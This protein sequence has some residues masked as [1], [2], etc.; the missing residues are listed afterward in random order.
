ML[1]IVK[2]SG[3]SMLVAALVV[4]PLTFSP[5]PEA[6]ADAIETNVALG[7]AT[8]TTNG[9]VKNAVSLAKLVDGDRQ[10]SA[11]ALI[12]AAAGPKWV[13]LDLGESF[14]V[15][16]VNVLNDF[17]PSEPRT[18]RDI[19]VQLSND[20]TF[21]S[22]VTTVFNNDAD[23]TA[24]QGAGTDAAYMEPTDGSG[25]NVT[26]SAP[27][28]ARYVRS[29]ANGHV[30][31]S[32]NSVQTV[33]TPVE[34][35]V[36][37]A[38]P[39]TNASL[40]SAV[41]LTA[42]SPGVNSVVL[43]WTSPG[44]SAVAGYDIRYSTSPITSANW[45][46]GLVVKRVTGEP[47]PA[48][49]STAQ[50]MTVKGLPSGTPLYFAMK[51]VGST[52]QVS[53][54]SSAVS[55]STL[56]VAN[57]ALG[58]PVTTN[59]TINASGQP[60]SAL[61]D[62]VKTRDAY[63]LYSVADGPKWAQIDLG[64]TYDIARINIRNDW[65]AS[66]DVYRYARDVVVQLS[67]DASFASGVVTAFN[68]DGDNSA[69]LGAGT[70]AEYMEPA[71]GSGKDILLADTV[72]ARYVRYW[73][74]GHVRVNGSV[75]TVDTPV[76]I[77]VYADPQDSSPPAAVTNLAS[78][79]VS[80][81]S[82]DLAWTA[83]GGDGNT[84]TAVAYDLRYATSAIT[85]SNWSS[86]TPVSGVPAP[87]TAGSAE[88]FTVTGLT[89]GTTYYFALKAKDLVN[90]SPISN[91]ATV[92]TPAADTVAP[93]AIA[94][95][96][97]TQAMFKSVK[98]TWTAPGDDGSN[99]KAA[100]YDV[101]YSTSPITASNWASATQAEDELP[102]PA[103]GTPMQFKV[104]ELTAGVTYYFAVRTTD[105]VG[106][107]S[108]LSNSASATIGTPTADAVTVSSL[109]ALQTAIDGAPAG[110]RV[111]T[112]AA[113][114]Y[115]QTTPINITGKNN[116]TIRGAGSNY[117]ATVVKGLGINDSALDINFKVNDSDYV[118]FKNMTIQDSYYHAIQV[119]LGSKYF[120][121]DGLKTW[122]NGEGGFKTTFDLNSGKG[123]TDY[124]IVENSLIGYT[125]SGMR[126]VVEGVDLIASKGWIVRGNRVENAKTSNNGGGYGIF[127][128]GNS[129]DTIFE[130][131]V[132]VGSFVAMSFGGGGT[133][134]TFFRNQDQ[135]YEHRGGIIRNNVVFGATDTGVYLNK[136]NG[137]KV[138]NNTILNTG[139]GVGAIE[140]RF[141]GTSG[142]VRNNLMTG[143]VK[144]RDSGTSVASNNITGATASWLVDPANG[145]YRLH[146]FNGMA[147]R[148]VGMTLADVP[149]DMYGEARPYGSAYDVGADEFAPSE[150]TPPAAIAN[151]TASDITSRTFRLTWTAAGDDGNTGTAY[152]YDI[153]Y[154]NA[155]I[156]ETNWSSAQ[157]A[158]ATLLPAAAGTSQSVK[159][160]GPTAGSVIYAAVKTVDD[161]GNVSPLSNIVQVNTPAASG[162]EF[163]PT[164][165]AYVAASGDRSG[166]SQSLI[167]LNN[168]NSTYWSYLKADFTGYSATHAE[169]AV[170]KLYVSD[171]PNN[172]SRPHALAVTGLI[173]DSWSESTV[174]RLTL[175]DETGALPLGSIQFSKPGWYEFDVTAFINS[176]MTDKIVTFKISDPQAQAARVDLN[177]SEHPYNK[178]FLLISETDDVAPAAVADLAAGKKTLSSVELGWTAPGDD[179]NVRTAAEYDVRYAASPI[180]ASNWASATPVIGGALA[181]D[182][183]HR[184]EVHRAGLDAGRDVLLR[185][186][187]EGR[188]EQRVGAL[189][190][191]SSRAGVD[192]QCRARQDGQH[193]WR[194]VRRRL[195]LGRDGRRPG[196]ERVCADQRRRR[197][198]VGA[199]GPR[200]DLC[201]QPDQRAERLGRHLRR[202]QDGPRSCRAAVQRSDVCNRRHDRLQQ[203]HGQQRGTR[204]G[205]RCGL[206][207]ADRRNGQKHRA[208]DARQCQVRQILG[209]RTCESD[210][211]R[212]IWSI[213]PVELEVYANTGDT[214]APGTIANLS[215]SGTTWKSTN[216]SWTAPGDDGTTGTAAS[217]DI[218][219]YTSSIT[220]N[221]WNDAVQLTNE[222]A[223]AP[224]GTTHTLAVTGLPAGTALYF[225]MRTFDETSNASALSNVVLVTTAAN[226][227]TPPA[228]IA[229]LA[230]VNPGPRSV[231]LTWTAPGNDGTAG[232]AEG[233]EVRYATSPITTEAQW[234]AAT[235]AEDELAQ[236]SP[237]QTMKYQVNQLQT[238]VTYYFAV[239]TY[240]DGGN[241]GGLSNPV[242][243]TTVTPTPDSVT[244]ASL[245]QLQQAIDQAPAQGRIITLAAGTYGQTATINING[246]NNI[247]IQGATSNYDDTVVAGPGI[248]ASSM[249][250]NFKVNDSD[251]V[252]FKNMTIRDSYYHAIQ[253][254]SG[255]DYFRADHLKTWDNGEGGFKST[256]GGSPDLPYAD[257]GI[258]EN[259][260]IGYTTGGTRSVV[261]GVDLIASRG[262]IIRGNTFQNAR[263]SGGGV[264][265]A[266]FA[267]GNSIDT[268][269]ENNVFQNSFIAMSFGGGGTA[270]QYFRNGDTSLEHRGG[271]M[272]NNVVYGTA[273]AGVYMNKASGFKVYNN[274]ILGIPSGVGAVESRFAGSSGDVR[275][276]LMDKAV[277][278]RDG[279]AATS[280]NNITNGTA[281][282]LV[283][284]AAGDYHL[285]PATASAAI[286]AGYALPADVPLD[287][288]GQPRPSGSAYDIGADELSQAPAAPAGLTASL[289]GGNVQLGWNLV[290]G[291]TSYT[292]KRATV[293]GGPYTS[294][295]TGV[296]TNAYTDNAAAAGATYYYTVSAANTAGSGPNAAEASVTVPLAAPTGVTATGGNATVSVGWTATSGAT[297]YNV[298]RGTVSGGPYSIVATSVTGAVYA[299]TTVSNGTTYYYVVSA[300]GSGG[301]SANSAQASATPSSGAA[302]SRTG[303]TA[304]SSTNTATANALDGNAT[305]RWTSSGS[306]SA[307]RYYQVNMGA[308]KTFNK[309]TLDSTGGSDYPRAY[310]VYVSSD[311]TTWGTAV[312]S[313]TGSGSVQT[314]TF[315]VQTARYIKV[316]LT[317]AASPWWSIYEF[318]VYEP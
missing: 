179:G 254:N 201:D 279:G 217:Y 255:S 229:D 140:P 128:K 177:S 119:N 312:A 98:L 295:A 32:N 273:D 144:N 313:G 209:Q 101:R 215:A 3:L 307:G 264:A 198:Q 87:K 265:Y 150:T 311:G 134:A 219:Y 83:P 138:Y 48:A 175:A 25:K 127:A 181:S 193:E 129:I 122:D 258:I 135:T 52:G 130:N 163:T 8:V 242:S 28:N 19:I 9:L 225:A 240:D 204:R 64:M 61:T 305:T 276:N 291:A 11:Y 223:P 158:D 77:E 232:M 277:K 5:A 283:N 156:T 90:E 247:T 44:P 208:D 253:V 207:G 72:G 6:H 17:N 93:A 297:G 213:P 170:L 261:E 211:G 120:H 241:Y 302:L 238:G 259:S 54:L 46:N 112:L 13:Q 160:E 115:N 125:A 132:I 271:I 149:T 233:Y 89:P 108:G 73:A 102:Q 188:R 151:L 267:K 221:N 224:A 268:L 59:G 260:L 246:K 29:W 281:S 316:V 81:K 95:L 42:G 70:D 109:S 184:A 67:N 275:N 239:K 226:D 41:G 63:S 315:P 191:G 278:L 195:R 133:G 4:S 16:R 148:D 206:P 106:N 172:P 317:A 76:E 292:V 304:T 7:H 245:S 68:N 220:E 308:A 194:G 176:Q 123:Y 33:N 218:R 43:S 161:Q 168:G 62:G 35:D 196:L 141:A 199:G 164:D 114:T 222:P 309:I 174:T 104:T 252:T 296:T 169:R 183:G 154:A 118:T 310:E 202:R 294:L 49:A 1:S 205:Q 314:V 190:R 136:A 84:G 280:S 21:A 197:P 293:A 256:S 263:M 100:S 22:G 86:A 300:V 111:I 53:A 257:Y 131:N 192:R 287:M 34:V 185:D 65:G 139:S 92:T 99:G 234:S 80:W 69:G 210:R 285:N 88:A 282:M 18:G 75:N 306:Q 2:K 318:N 235:Q 203:R 250:I 237:G 142:E 165:D 30:R 284:A 27:V 227:P 155:P 55:A 96:Q 289:V 243:A 162:S 146:P 230:A 228:A 274:T 269:V 231:Q 94:N 45:D 180:T 58:K 78:T 266:F 214:T 145:D 124:G 236:K 288:D 286:D 178:P 71:D 20:P 50:S 147:A 137:Y 270:P 166:T 97:A 14:D 290:S 85:A 251:Y 60:I 167:I 121:A 51:T 216:L 143:T 186:E 36:Y 74:N 39:A 301:E 187:D 200:S 26:L 117:T 105:A 66:A 10:A 24:G 40:P 91:V 299:D 79:F 212:R 57:I 31:S 189:Q 56:P 12:D 244:V 173:N 152:A 37:A 248:N 182:G 272:R 15:T 116:I 303:W 38:V 107:V 153:R 110:G 171:I 23:N 82:A 262:W 298:K 126:S 113:G 103:A 157:K 159:I 47:A 249:D